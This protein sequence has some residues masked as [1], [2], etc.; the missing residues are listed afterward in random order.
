MV[1]VFKNNLIVIPKIKDIVKKLYSTI[2]LLKFSDLL[3]GK[4][5]YYRV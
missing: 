1:L 3:K 5:K 2:Y 4:I